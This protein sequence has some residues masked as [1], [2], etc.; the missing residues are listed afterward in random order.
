MRVFSGGM[1]LLVNGEQELQK[2]LPI[3]GEVARQV[4]LESALALPVRFGDEVIAVLEMFSDR[5]HAPGDET[6]TLMSDISAQMGRVLER[7]RSTA[8]MADL[9]WREQQA[10]L[11]TLHDALGQTLMGLGMLAAGLSQR[12]RRGESADAAESARQIS[13]QAQQAL[14]QVRSLARGLFPMDVGG[15]GLADA[16]R[17]LGATTQSLHKLRVKV[18]A[19]DQSSIRDGRVATQLY[20]IAQEAVTN[21]VKHAHAST[22]HILMRSQAGT[23]TLRVADDGVGIRNTVPTHDGVGLRI[24][25]HRATSVGGALTIEPG[26]ERGTVVTCTVRGARPVAAQGG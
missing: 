6:V 3:R 14:E 5:P 24:M 4:G 2:A 15:E 12:L 23:T 21:A 8:Q 13:E 19:D 1:Q 11:H 26:T 18:E 7:E 17:D 20:R 16:L 22:I 25:Q 10:L 9:V